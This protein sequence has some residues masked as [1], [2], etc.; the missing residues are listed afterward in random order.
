VLLAS[1]QASLPMT[2]NPLKQLAVIVQVPGFGTSFF[3]DNRMF[4]N[5]LEF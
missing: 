3:G 2:D 5:S 1:A 4:I